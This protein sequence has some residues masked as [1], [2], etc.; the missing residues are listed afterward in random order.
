ML[1]MSADS[2]RGCLPGLFEVFGEGGELSFDL[3]TALVL[4]VVPSEQREAYAQEIGAM[5]AEVGPAVT[6][7]A[8]LDRF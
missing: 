4:S 5:R 7:E 6:L 1:A 8:V 2:V 3:F